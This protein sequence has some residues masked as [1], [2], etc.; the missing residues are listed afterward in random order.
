[1][2]KNFEEAKKDPRFDQAT[3]RILLTP[4]QFDELEWKLVT[5]EEL[6]ELQTHVDFNPPKFYPQGH[7]VEAYEVGHDLQYRYQLAE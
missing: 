5:A 4:E 2:Y 7:F 3:L 6:G 1:M